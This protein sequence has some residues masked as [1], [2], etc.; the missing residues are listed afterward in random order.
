MSI[1]ISQAGPDE[2]WSELLAL[3]HR[4]FAFMEGRIDP[5]SSLHLLDPSG[6]KAKATAEICLLARDGG[7]IIGCVFCEPRDRTLYI[8]KLAVDP[9]HQ[10]Q[11]VGRALLARAEAEARVRN[12]PM[13][14]LQ[15]RVEL[16]DNHEA[17]VSMGFIR[18]GETNHPGYDRPTS[19]T[20]RKT[21]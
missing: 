13:L 4:A 11:G 3:L 19:V 8:G 9:A 12:L 2:E 21:V 7:A 16:T 6:L 18:T 14:E 15:T 20:M 17:F 5:P 10:G 1:R